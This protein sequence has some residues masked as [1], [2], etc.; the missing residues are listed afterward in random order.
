MALPSI[1]AYEMPTA[2]DHIANRVD[3]SLDPRRAV[4]LVHDLQEHFIGAFEPT[5]GGPAEVAIANVR[6]LREAADVAGMPVVYTAQPPQQ[7]P[8]DR[9]LLSD[10]W[11]PGLQTDDSARIVSAVAPRDHDVLLT[12][13]RYNAFIRTPLLELLQDWGRD[14]I[15]VVGVYAHIGVLLT[16]ADA[17]MHDIAPFVVSDAVADFSREHHVQALDYAA[18]RCATVL[19]TEAAVNA[20]AAAEAVTGR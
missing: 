8:E 19:S 9:G 16:A 15:V 10:F 3:W 4:L 20:V 12:K 5:G 17:F 6:R 1:A 2:T 13:W 11:G 7:Q 18:E 14:Q